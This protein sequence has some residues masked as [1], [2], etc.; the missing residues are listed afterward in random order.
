MAYQWFKMPASFAFDPT[1]QMLS[2]QAQRRYVVLL[3][4]RC[5]GAFP[6]IEEASGERLEALRERAAKRAAFILRVA[7]EQWLET[8]AELTAAGLLDERYDFPA[9]AQEATS[10]ETEERAQPLSAAERSR[11][12]RIRRKRE[13]A[14]ADES[15]TTRDESATAR[16]ESA[17]FRATTE[18]KKEEIYKKEKKEKNAA[19]AVASPSAVEVNAADVKY[20]DSR[21]IKLKQAYLPK[22]NDESRRTTVAPTFRRGSPIPLNAIIKDD[23]LEAMFAAID[24]AEEAHNAYWKKVEDAAAKPRA[25]P[26]EEHYDLVERHYLGADG[27]R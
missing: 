27:G 7:Q 26:S 23:A 16:D 11:R 22:C 1:F 3:C 17:T 9:E 6:R 15:A 10:G 8:E 24:K 18:K 12:Y 2:E 5:G 14:S 4:A 19:E 20:D 13:S 25:S 21:G